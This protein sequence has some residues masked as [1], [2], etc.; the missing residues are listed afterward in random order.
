[1]QMQGQTQSIQSIQ[2]VPQV[3]QTGG[4]QEIQPAPFTNAFNTITI[5]TR[6]IQ[7]GSAERQTRR[8]EYSQKGREA[9]APSAPSASA[10]ITVRKVG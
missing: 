3:I 10:K 7:G 6:P 4:Y 2:G 1:M 9:P 5:D 8:K